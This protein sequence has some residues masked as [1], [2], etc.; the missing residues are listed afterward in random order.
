MTKRHSD[1][2]KHFIVTYTL[3]PFINNF[4]RALITDH[5]AMMYYLWLQHSIHVTYA[6]D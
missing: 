5:N 4:S 1:Q 3:H 2:N 6:G